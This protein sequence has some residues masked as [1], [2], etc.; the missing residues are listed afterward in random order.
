MPTVD[1]PQVVAAYGEQAG[2]YVDMI[3]ANLAEPGD[4][5]AL[6]E[7]WS[8][9]L[10]A[11]RV[12]DAGCGPGHWS[13]LLHAR[14]CEVEAFDA[15]PAFVDHARRTYPDVSVR[16]GDLRRLEVD[17]ASCGGILAWFSAI[18]LPPS[19]V[20]G[21]LAG[22]AEALVPSGQLLLGYF[23]GPELRPFDHRVV[24]AWA[25]PPT[26]VADALAAAGLELVEQHEQPA[27]RDRVH[28]WVIARKVIDA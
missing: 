9:P 8:A 7:R 1:L 23:T 22:F 6:I 13:A 15:T 14:G 12:L 3:E 25:W 26:F 18:H 10:P 4:E 11:G 28:A 20:A 16:L 5:R 17:A 24:Q 19:E 21:V 27:P 2:L